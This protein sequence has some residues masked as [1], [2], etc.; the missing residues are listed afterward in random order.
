MA[1]EFLT[2]WEVVCF[3]HFAFSLWNTRTSCAQHGSPNGN[4][5]DRFLTPNLTQILPTLPGNQVLILAQGQIWHVVTKCQALADRLRSVFTKLHLVFFYSSTRFPT[6]YTTSG[7]SRVA[8]ASIQF[9]E[10]PKSGGGE[11]ESIYPYTPGSLC[12][13]CC[14]SKMPRWGDNKSSGSES[15]YASGF[16]DSDDLTYLAQL[17]WIS[18][19]RESTVVDHIN[20][21][22]WWTNPR[23]FW[24]F[25]IFGLL[26]AKYHSQSKPTHAQGCL[27]MLENPWDSYDS[28]PMV[29]VAKILQI[30]WKSIEIHLRNPIGFLS[31]LVHISTFGIFIRLDKLLQTR[32]FNQTYSILSIKLGSVEQIWITLPEKVPVV[33]RVR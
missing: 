32:K 17:V 33:C 9:T 1:C 7:P 5:R 28:I 24:K 3:A 14:S 23:K 10:Q 2:M 27:G 18:S 13:I 26:F 16:N 11:R 31:I 4:V 19:G 22:N 12:H 29:S 25:M 15:G 8:H 21:G 6:P 30:Q 20:D